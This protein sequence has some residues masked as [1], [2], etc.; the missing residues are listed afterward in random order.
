MVVRCRLYLMSEF[1]NLPYSMVPAFYSVVCTSKCV[2]RVGLMVSIFSIRT[3]KQQTN[4]GTRGNSGR[5]WISLSP[6]LWWWC[7][8]C[9]ADIQTHQIVR[10]RCTQL[11]VYQLHLSKAVKKKQNSTRPSARG[12]GDR[13]EGNEDDKG[14]ITL[15]GPYLPGLLA[16]LRAALCL[17]WRHTYIGVE[18]VTSEANACILIV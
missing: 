1:W 13:K 8:G 9:C 7:H 11:L 18:R 16:S 5:W 6:R 17:G 15:W 4:K 2:R 14:F 12:S 10:I 3:D